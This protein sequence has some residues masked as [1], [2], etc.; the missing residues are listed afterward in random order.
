[1]SGLINVI[2]M[3]CVQACVCIYLGIFQ[4]MFFVYICLS[5][6]VLMNL[7]SVYVYVSLGMYVCKYASSFV[8]FHKC[9]WIIWV[10]FIE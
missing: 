9:V 1:M 8:R 4:Y 10:N 3:K 6:R 7:F 2:F 5:L